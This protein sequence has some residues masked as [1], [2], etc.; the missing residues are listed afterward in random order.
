MEPSEFRETQNALKQVLVR[1]G[2]QET[3]AEELSFNLV[4]AVRNV[5]TLLTLLSKSESYSS[6]KIMN[7][8]YDVLANRFALQRAAEML[9]LPPQ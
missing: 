5:P 6:E 2:F 4:Q 7:A 9:H 8:T 3:F 1:E